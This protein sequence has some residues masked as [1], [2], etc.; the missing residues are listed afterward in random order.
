MECF[1]IKN[2]TNSSF[3][4]CLV[5]FWKIFYSVVRKIEQKDRG[6][7]GEACVFGK[8]FTKKLGVNHFPNFN[9]GFSSQ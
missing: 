5:A 2:I 1:N 6:G 4:L 3:F 8:W 7:G 9:K